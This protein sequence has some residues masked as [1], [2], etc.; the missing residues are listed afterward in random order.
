MGS[1]KLK[2]HVGKI[3][4]A[5]TVVLLALIFRD[6]LSSLLLRTERVKWGEREFEFTSTDS[7]SKDFSGSLSTV[8]L[9]YL[10][11]TSIKSSSNVVQ[12][13]IRYEDRAQ[14][15][16]DEL[17]E[18]GLVTFNIIETVDGS[19]EMRGKWA[20]TELTKEGKSLLED[21]GLEFE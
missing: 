12:S 3:V 4:I 5:V 19:P 18:K 16:L 21:L 8:S 9:Y 10:L 14:A 20:E 17:K 7:E 13:A 1:S 2:E 15:A 11:N 6:A